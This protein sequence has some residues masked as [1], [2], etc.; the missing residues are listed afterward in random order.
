MLLARGRGSTL[1]FWGLG[2]PGKERNYPCTNTSQLKFWRGKQFAMFASGK[3]SPEAVSAFADLLSESG[4]SQAELSR[5]MGVK[6]SSVTR[7][8]T[9]EVPKYA[10]SYRPIPSGKVVIVPAGPVVSGQAVSASA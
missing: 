9:T 8:K 7:W 4:L 5:R 1:L 3:H 6:P 10:V 2:S